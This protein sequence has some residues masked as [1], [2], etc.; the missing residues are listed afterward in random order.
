[1]KALLS[2][3]LTFLYL[4]YCKKDFCCTYRSKQHFLQPLL[5]ERFRFLFVCL[6]TC[7]TLLHV[8]ELKVQTLKRQLV[9]FMVAFLAG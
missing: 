7:T 9:F 4:Y 2:L 6:I 8:R 3:D 5:N 1:M